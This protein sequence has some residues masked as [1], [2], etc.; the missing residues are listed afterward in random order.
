MGGEIVS[1][2]PLNQLIQRERQK[3]WQ[4]RTLINSQNNLFTDIEVCKMQ[5]RI[6]AM[7]LID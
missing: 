4:F 2:S 5:N 1:S 6:V 7:W 3:S